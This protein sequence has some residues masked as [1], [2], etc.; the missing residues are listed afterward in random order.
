[1]HTRWL[2][3]NSIMEWTRSLTENVCVCVCVKSLFN[4]CAVA[5]TIGNCWAIS[6]ATIVGFS[7]LPGFE[8]NGKEGKEV[9]NVNEWMCRFYPFTTAVRRA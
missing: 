8:W 4:M 7:L 9:M 5:I 1:M 2:Q 6:G 3:N